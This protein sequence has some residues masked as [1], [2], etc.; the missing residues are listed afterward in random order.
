MKMQVAQAKP[1][2]AYFAHLPDQDIAVAVAV[3]IA[4]ASKYFLVVDS[5]EGLEEGLSCASPS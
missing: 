3:I 1:P 4:S 5:L 2:P